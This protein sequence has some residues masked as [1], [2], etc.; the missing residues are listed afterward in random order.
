MNKCCGKSV[1][2]QTETQTERQKQPVSQPD[3]DTDTD[4][5]RQTDKMDATR[6]KERKLARVERKRGHIRAK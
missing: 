6:K 5:H 4:R 2:A 1:H 3:T